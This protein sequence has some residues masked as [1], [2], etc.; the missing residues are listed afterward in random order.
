MGFKDPIIN[1]GCAVAIYNDIVENG[2]KRFVSTSS[3]Y[4]TYNNKNMILGFILLL[5]SIG[6]KHRLM[7]Y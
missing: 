4:S 1:N 7:M 5:A 3:Y 2:V 6:L